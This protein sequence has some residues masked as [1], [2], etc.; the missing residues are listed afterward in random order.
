[1]ITVG[2]GETSMDSVC[3]PKRGTTLWTG[4]ASGSH[5]DGLIAS[6]RIHL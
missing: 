2:F 5:F 4:K 6:K 3:N 1:M